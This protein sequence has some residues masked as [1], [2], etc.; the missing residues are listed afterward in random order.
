MSEIYQVFVCGLD[1]EMATINIANTEKE[2]LKTT[3]AR[4]RSLIYEKC[5][6]LGNLHHSVRLLWAGKQLEETLRDGGLATFEYY[7]IER[8]STI[9]IV[10]RLLG[11]SQPPYFP[12]RVPPV[13]NQ[14]NQHQAEDYSLHSGPSSNSH[15]CSVITLN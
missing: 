4:F 1:G 13:E 11:G 14:E 9:N 12:H 10:L 3:I 6:E 15:F 7:K 2:F 5:P 8:Y